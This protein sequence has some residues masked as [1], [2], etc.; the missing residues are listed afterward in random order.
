MVKLYQYIDTYGMKNFLWN[1]IGRSQIP[2][3]LA[4][5]I[6]HHKVGV[7]LDCAEVD[8]GKNI[9]ECGQVIFALSR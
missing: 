3:K 5:A 4:W 9:F 6:T 1:K 7:S 2:L 8:V